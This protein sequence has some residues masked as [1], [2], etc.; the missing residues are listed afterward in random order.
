[1]R[2]REPIKIVDE[3]A[4]RCESYGVF[5][6][7]KLNDYHALTMYFTCRKLFNSSNKRSRSIAIDRA[8][9]SY[10]RLPNYLKL[11]K[12]L[13][14]KK[15]RVFNL[16]PLFGGRDA[17]NKFLK[18]IGITDVRGCSVTFHPSDKDLE[19]CL[20]ADNNISVEYINSNSFELEMHVQNNRKCVSRKISFEFLWCFLCYT[21][22]LNE[23]LCK[24]DFNLVK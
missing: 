10:N 11:G 20:A 3:I 18:D 21:Y 16:E 9:E 7:D 2:K 1:M 8:V 13:I 23:F 24:H 5:Y 12:I 14:T 22:K 4:S 19:T 17:M 15:F 6:P